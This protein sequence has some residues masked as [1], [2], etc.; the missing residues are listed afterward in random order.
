MVYLSGS[1]SSPLTNALSVVYWKLSIGQNLFFFSA[2]NHWLEIRWEV[3]DFFSDL[4]RFLVLNKYFSNLS[5]DPGILHA[6][7]NLEHLAAM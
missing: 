4:P 3:N 1:S 2:S 5:F 6:A 7:E